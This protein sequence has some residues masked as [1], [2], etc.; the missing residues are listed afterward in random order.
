MP[1]V[2]VLTKSNIEITSV[3]DLSEEEENKNEELE[4]DV[5]INISIVKENKFLAIFTLKS[6]ILT[7]S[8]KN[9][10]RDVS[11]KKNPPPE[12]IG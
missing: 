2:L 11:S 5:E 4:K 1:T 8:F 6:S 12:F 7:R 3:I 9:Y 10:Q